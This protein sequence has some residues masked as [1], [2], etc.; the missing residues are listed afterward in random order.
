MRVLWST[1]LVWACLSSCFGCGESSTDSSS[2]NTP[3]SNGGQIQYPSNGGVLG[4]GGVIAVGGTQNPA[5]SGNGG[6]LSGGGLPNGSGGFVVGN[7]GIANG[8]GGV[9]DTGGFVGNGGLVNTGGLFDTGGFVGNGGQP[10]TGGAPAGTGGASVGP[11]PA[12][13]YGVAVGNTFPNIQLQGYVNDSA[14]GLANT[15]PFVDLYTMDDLRVSGARYAL[16]HN[17]EFF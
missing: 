14:V 9:F 8:S 10:A 1:V 11:Y 4:G 3:F 13:P 12:G 15:K 6:I 16:I 7:G 2:S 5:G 17:S